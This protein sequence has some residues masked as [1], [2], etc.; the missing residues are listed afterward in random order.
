MIRKAEHTDICSRVRRSRI[1][2]QPGGRSSK[3]PIQSPITGR[4]L[5]LRWLLIVHV[6]ERKHTLAQHCMEIDMH[7]P[8]ASASMGVGR[9]PGDEI[10]Q[11]IWLYSRL[12]TWLNTCLFFHWRETCSW[13]DGLP[14]PTWCVRC[15]MF[16]CLH[17]I[18]PST[19]TRSISTDCIL[20]E[21]LSEQLSVI[22]YWLQVRAYL[23]KKTRKA[24]MKTMH[25][26]GRKGI[27]L[28]FIKSVGI[29]ICGWMDG[30]GYVMD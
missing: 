8:A 21:S 29:S 18:P 20:T 9:V 24:K 4:R 12:V 23:G 19:A 3:S 30:Y 2:R 13:C 15:R 17:L 11:S 22:R 6:E 10:Y 28:V 1:R 7:I 14:L 27:R 16:V 25:G 26:R 5:R